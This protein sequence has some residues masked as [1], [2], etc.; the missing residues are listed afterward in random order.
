MKN[1][2]STFKLFLTLLF[3]ISI[4][5]GCQDEFESNMDL[6][7]DVDITEFVVPGTQS[8]KIDNK[9]KTIVITYPKG[10]NV[11]NIIPNIKVSEGAES[12]GFRNYSGP[13]IAENFY[14]Y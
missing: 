1:I 5:S 2:K 10:S 13:K 8:I 7:G 6:F 4:M 14:D 11:S 9:K 12:R 3:M